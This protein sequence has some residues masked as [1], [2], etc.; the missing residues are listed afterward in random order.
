MILGDITNLPAELQTIIQEDFLKRQFI[1]G[2]EA[3]LAFAAIAQVMNFPTGIGESLTSTR[4]GLYALTDLDPIPP[5]QLTSDLNNGLTAEKWN[6]EQFT[7]R[8]GLYAKRAESTDS[9]TNNATIGSIFMHNT[10]ALGELAGRLLDTLARNALFSAYLSGNSFV[11]DTLGAPAL[12]LHV[13]NIVGFDK[14][15]LSTITTQGTDMYVP[16]SVTNPLN[17]TVSAIANPAGNVYICTGAVADVTNISSVKALGGI[18]GT[19][20]FTTNVTVLDGTAGSGLVSEFA[21][22]VYRAGDQ[23]SSYNLTASDILTLSDLRSAVVILRDNSVP[24]INGMYNIYLT[25]TSMAQLYKDEEFK[26]LYASNPTI[27]EYKNFRIVETS[28]LRFIVNQMSPFILNNNIIVQRPIVCGGGALVRGQ[29]EAFLSGDR[30]IG[31]P[32]SSVV[33]KDFATSRNN[34]KFILTVRPP[35]DL[36]G[37]IYDQAFQWIGGHVVPTDITATSEIIPTATD[38]YFKR[39]VVIETA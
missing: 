20:T 26:T 33:I 5:S 12:T 39:A 8:M 37:K 7:M 36:L 29:N 38:S 28:G 18:S 25:E 30:I 21:P 15:Y 34:I 23:V 4:A 35:M 3:N 6:V 10:Y 24:L 2:L 32:N 16:V 9:Q 27:S 22:V 14:V 13:D 31:A 19:L 11:L 1:L 17:V